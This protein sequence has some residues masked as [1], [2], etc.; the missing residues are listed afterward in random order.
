MGSDIQEVGLRKI[1]RTF[2]GFEK[3]IQNNKIQIYGQESS[4]YDP[5]RMGRGQTG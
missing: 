1:I 5:R 2:V 4:T 3:K